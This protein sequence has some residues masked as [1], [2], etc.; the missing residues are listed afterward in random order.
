MG[1]S[2]IRQEYTAKGYYQP[3]EPLR[4]AAPERLSLQSMTGQVGDRD[5]PPVYSPGTAA[6]EGDM[7][8]AQML[9]EMERG[10]YR[11][12]GILATN[13][14]DRLFLAYKVRQ[15]CPEARLTFILS[16]SLYTHHDLVPYLRGSLIASTYP[17]KLANQSWSPAPAVDKYP[18]GEG[19]P[20]RVSPL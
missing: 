2:R 15:I 3:N 5:L 8:L 19:S 11:W 7:A 9:Q 12:I 1:I 16:S 18:F 10:R 17:L 6:V 14:Y 4:L 20:R 13:P